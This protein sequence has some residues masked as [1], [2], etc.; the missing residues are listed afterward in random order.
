MKATIIQ[1]WWRKASGFYN[2][3]EL[4]EVESYLLDL[5]PILFRQSHECEPDLFSYETYSDFKKVDVNGI[6]IVDDKLKEI[7]P[8]F[9][10]LLNLIIM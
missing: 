3:F 5:P 4:V 6:T 9:R 10:G 1:R 8:T 7:L 2:G